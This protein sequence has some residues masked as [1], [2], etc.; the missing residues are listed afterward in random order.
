MIGIYGGT[1]DPIHYGHLRTALE[2]R[3]ATGMDEIRFIPS[4][5]PPHRKSPGASPAQRLAMLKAAF[6]ESPEPHFSI[7]TREID[8]TG[9]SY[10][11][12]T[13]TSIRTETGSQK[14][15]CLIIGL[16]ALGGLDRWYHWQD[17]FKLAHIVVMQR[18]GPPP[19]LSESL[20][21]QVNQRNTEAAENL[22]TQPGGLIHFVKVTQLDISATKIRQALA[23]HK[24]PRYLT[25]EP[26]I[27]LINEWNLYQDS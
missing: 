13:L 6:S 17:L 21:S 15:L 20:A 10:M 7:D 26:V 27:Q 11:V 16:D 23:T 22:K 1:F 12:D 5:Q 24:S 19:H 2:V 25:P 4:F 3:E 18:P 9:P 8:R 14:P